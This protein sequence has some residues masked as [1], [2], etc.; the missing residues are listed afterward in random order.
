MKAFFSKS[1]QAN[2]IKVTQIYNCK[3]VPNSFTFQLSQILFLLFS[4]EN[5]DRNKYGASELSQFLFIGS[6][7]KPMIEKSESL[8]IQPPFVASE[9]LPDI[10]VAEKGQNLTPKNSEKLCLIIYLLLKIEFISFFFFNLLVD[11]SCNI[12]VDAHHFF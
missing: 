1:L 9:A 4:M 8:P 11:V 7:M 2:K 12:E 10:N 6:N 3:P 5:E